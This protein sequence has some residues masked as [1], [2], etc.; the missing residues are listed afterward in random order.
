MTSK[1]ILISVTDKTGIEKFARLLDLGF[2]IISTGGT[3]KALK[4]LGIICTLI[5][6]VTGFPEMMDG[7][8]KTLHPNIFGGILADRRKAD[9]LKAIA[10]HGI[11][12]IDI[13]VVNLYDF[14]NN[15]GIEHID[16]GGPSLLRA[17]AKN[18]VSTLPVVD[19]H[20]YD[21]VIEQIELRGNFS[22][23]LRKA[24]CVKVFE[25]TAHYDKAI[26]QWMHEEMHNTHSFL[27]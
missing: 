13:V 26:Y 21:E 10:S 25:H 27:E 1:R 6:E 11:E 24:L 14:N 20:D 2:E 15:K 3:A 4:N 23:T 19:P 22:M 8:L 16:I 17:A 7:R 18:G 12:L 5:E 9:H